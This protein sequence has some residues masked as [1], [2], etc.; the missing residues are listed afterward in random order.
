MF[1]KWGAKRWIIKVLI[2]KFLLEEAVIEDFESKISNIPKY[3]IDYK[4]VFFFKLWEKKR[5][6]FIKNQEEY[7]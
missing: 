3:K 2:Q 1:K 5:K 6:I 4:H 7:Y